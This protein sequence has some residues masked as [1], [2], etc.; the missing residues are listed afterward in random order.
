MAY[1]WTFGNDP[2]KLEKFC[3]RST[4]KYII[5]YG[6]TMGLQKSSLLNQL[7][8]VAIDLKLHSGES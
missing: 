3:E 7:K 4:I 2:L 8:V 5:D 6:V 1:R